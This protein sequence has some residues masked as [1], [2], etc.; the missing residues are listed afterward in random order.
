MVFRRTALLLVV[1]LGLLGGCASSPDATGPMPEGKALLDASAATLRDLHTV[2]F[3]AKAN[4]ALPGLSI[5]TVSG[6]ASRDGGRY[7][8]ARGEADVQEHTDRVQ[9]DFLLSGDRVRLTDPEGRDTQREVAEQFSPARL[10][11]PERG[12]YQLLAHARNVRTETRE[13]LHDVPAYRVA[14]QLSRDVV[15]S[16]IPGVHDDV[17]VKFWVGAGAQRTLLRLWLQV[18]PQQKNQ[19]AVML[20]LALTDHNRP[21]SATPVR[22]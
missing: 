3:E 17:D 1:I 10:L 8:Y 18:P 15:S 5:R 7:G 21:V 12:L 13:E 14:G 19:G 4:G 9:Y 2:R 16:V 22:D 11:D 20:E 6:V